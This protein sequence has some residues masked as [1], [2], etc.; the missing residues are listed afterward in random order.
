VGAFAVLVFG[1]LATIPTGLA[2]GLVTG[3]A[4]AI[5]CALALYRGR[6]GSTAFWQAPEVRRRIGIGWLLYTANAM[7]YWGLTVFL[8]TFMVQ[9]FDVSATDAITYAILFYVAQFCFSYLGTGLS[10]RIGRRPAGVLGALIMMTTTVLAATAGDL[11]VFLVFGAI[12]IAMLGWLWGVGD[13]YLSEMF[14]TS[15]RGSGFGIGVGGG[16]VMS[17]A[18]PFLTGAGIAAFGPT[19]PFLASAGL[20]VLTIV[21]YLLGPE[22]ARKPLE[23]IEDEFNAIARRDEARWTRET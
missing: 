10:D 20:W 21:G 15:I 5:L 22:T 11:T 16:R 14:P 9:K 3:G 7:G 4:L 8:T 6:P 1:L 19:T 18:A 13:T 2:A 12:Q 23:Q 17:I